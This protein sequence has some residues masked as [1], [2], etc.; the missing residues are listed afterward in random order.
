MSRTPTSI[1]WNTVVYAGAMLAVP[2][3]FGGG[4]SRVVC[5]PATAEE[6]PRS[7]SW[8]VMPASAPPTGEVDTVFTVTIVSEPPGANVYIDQELV[9]QTPMQLEREEGPVNLRL[10]LEGYASAPHTQQVD[11]FLDAKVTMV[12]EEEANRPTEVCNHVG[13][14]FVL[15]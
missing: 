6:M 4:G 12:T 13:R 7:P 3:C 14:G 9:G 10:E 5:R 15:A 1:I 11:Q 8:E 2:G